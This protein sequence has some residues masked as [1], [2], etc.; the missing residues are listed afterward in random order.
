MTLILPIMDPPPPVF[1]R[2]PEMEELYQEALAL[3]KWK[4][5]RI[6]RAVDNVLNGKTGVK[7]APSL[8]EKNVV[9]R[10]LT[11]KL[12]GAIQWRASEDK[13]LADIIA[14]A[15]QIFANGLKTPR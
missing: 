14:D 12:R 6:P 3:T 5:E 15:V 10:I 1:P 13:E 11:R 8:P 4:R 7:V 2:D 9:R